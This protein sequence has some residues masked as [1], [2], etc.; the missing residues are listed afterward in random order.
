M[1][2][3]R[4]P[5]VVAIAVVS[6]AAAV[7]AA[8]RS[9]STTPPQGP[10]RT[11]AAPVFN[12]VLFEESVRATMSSL[13]KGYAFAVA[14]RDGKIQ[15][16]AA[17]GWAQ[18]PSDGNV[19][20]ATT[21][22]SGI[23]SVTK[24]MSGAA[25]LHLF[26][27]HALANTSVAA[28]LDMSMLAKLPERWQTQ[29]RGRNLERIT[30]RHLMQH[31]SGFRD[32]SCDATE[33]KP[34]QYLADGVKIPD[35]GK[36]R[37]YNNFNIYLLRYLIVSIA[38]PGEAAAIHKKYESLSLEEYTEKVSVAFSHEYERFLRQELFPRSLDPFP[39][40]CRPAE[41]P[42]REQVGQ[43][44]CR[45]GRQQ[46]RVRARQERRARSGLPLRVAGQLVQLGRR[47][48]AVRPQSPLHRS[49]GQ[50]GNPAP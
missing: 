33:R 49:L 9:G 11:P 46:G 3:T 27:R 8:G 23:G 50:P 20:M 4:G 34:L 18:T 30:Y 39:A 1:S 35:V 22:V 21:T 38:Y 32:G 43:G 13:V 2:V 45:Q 17:G 15:A 12:G 48:R 41:G 24:M 37:C 26:E 40:T 29:W 36:F 25:L 19:R 5:F 28:Q 6:L 16:R 42:G 47:A 7:T 14:D 31:K 44:L 10:R